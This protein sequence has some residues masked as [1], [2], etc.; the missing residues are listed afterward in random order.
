MRADGLAR[1]TGIQEG[2]NYT[3]ISTMYEV[4]ALFRMVR[5]SHRIDLS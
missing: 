1:A 5:H 4:E 3:A 2:K